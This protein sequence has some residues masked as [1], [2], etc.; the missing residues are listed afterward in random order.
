MIT[1]AN[2]TPMALP[3]VSAVRSHTIMAPTRGDSRV[4]LAA[5]ADAAGNVGIDADAADV[6][7]HAIDDEHI[8][9]VHRQARHV[10]LREI[11]QT[12]LFAR[13]RIGLQHLD[14]QRLVKRILHEA[15]A[16]ENLAR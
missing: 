8:D 12:R 16:R 7:A 2:P 3:C 10:A 4:A 5:D 1:S 15:D 6:F 11:Q 9:G 14:V 13:Y